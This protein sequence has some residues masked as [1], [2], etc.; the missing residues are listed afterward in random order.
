MIGKISRIALLRCEKHE[1]N[2]KRQTPVIMPGEVLHS[3]GSNGESY[4]HTPG[5]QATGLFWHPYLNYGKFPFCN[6]N[7]VVPD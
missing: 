4:P 3:E 7:L 6:L 1:T 2:D 5:S